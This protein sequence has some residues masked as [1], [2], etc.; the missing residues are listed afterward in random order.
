MKK[1]QLSIIIVLSLLIVAPIL[2]S[3][4]LK[5]D[6]SN[7]VDGIVTPQANK[8]IYT[9]PSVPLKA[10]FAGHYIDLSRG[11]LRERMDRE[12]MSFNY[13]HSTSMLLIK[14]ANRFFPIIEPILK[15]NDMPDDLKY[16]MV[17]ESSVDPFAVS[18]A[19]AAGLWQ[20]M[21]AT[22]RELGLE[23]NNNIDERFHVEKS[24]VA[25][26]KYLKRAYDK[27]GDWLTAAASYNAGQGRISGE[28]EKQGVED[29]T[30][31]W[32]VPETTRYMFRLLAVK[33]FMEDPKEF[34]F[35]LKKEQLY[36]VIQ[37][38]EVVVKTGIADLTTFAKKY[39]VTYAQLKD[40]NPWLKQRNLA[41]RSGR[42]YKIQIPLK[43]SLNYDPLATRAHN[44]NWTN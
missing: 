18:P 5:L 1:R 4:T 13:M 36:P 27:Y 2:I 9:A 28:L 42:T 37:Y 40:A 35:Y 17:I 43:E 19:G 41:N 3:G 26:C 15:E 32:L 22:G 31:L 6:S 10:A 23:V 38:K 11:D 21:K 14:R 20:I 34:G 24:T 30:D 33:Q 39:G 12:L 16:L 25:A 7:K 29:A 44:P 8:Q